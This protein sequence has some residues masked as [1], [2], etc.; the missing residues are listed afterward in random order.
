[1]VLVWGVLWGEPPPPPPPPPRARH[2]V[3]W[4]RAACALGQEESTAPEGEG[5]GGWGSIL[6]T[7]L[8]GFEAPHCSS[9][10]C[11]PSL[12]ILQFLTCLALRR[13][14]PFLL[15]GTQQ[16]PAVFQP[17]LNL[18]FQPRPLSPPYY[19]F[20]QECFLFSSPHPLIPSSGDAPAFIHV[21]TRQTPA[22]R[23]PSP[24]VSGQPSYIIPDPECVNFDVFVAFLSSPWLLPTMHSYTQTSNNPKTVT[25]R[26]F[27]RLFSGACEFPPGGAPPPPPPP[28]P[29]P[30]RRPAPPPAYREQ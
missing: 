16:T 17:L 5:E 12:S 24:L 8:P 19:P 23:T 15:W 1:M 28:P 2:R 22:K 30:P 26:F 3:V 25:H 27:Q 10:P 18:S 7:P 9:P 14:L 11:P 21:K 20:P 29:D 6:S 4:A 13:V